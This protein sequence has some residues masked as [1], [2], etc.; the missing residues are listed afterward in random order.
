MRGLYALSMKEVHDPTAL[1][2]IE[3]MRFTSDKFLERLDSLQFTKEGTLQK[4]A[5]LIVLL[6]GD[7]LGR[8]LWN[9]PY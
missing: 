2:Y 4:N 9:T 1:R 8:K 6:R 3:K 7:I 5:N